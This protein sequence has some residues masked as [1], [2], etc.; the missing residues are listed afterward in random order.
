MLYC[1]F[2]RNLALCY[3][4]IVAYCFSYNISHFQLFRKENVLMAL[5]HAKFAVKLGSYDEAKLL[6]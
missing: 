5:K 4:V 3:S 2:W 1:K 6:N